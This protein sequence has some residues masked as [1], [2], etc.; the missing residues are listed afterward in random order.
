[1]R[2]HYSAFVGRAIGQS[3]PQLVAQIEPLFDDSGLTFLNI[4]YRLDDTPVEA[5]GTVLAFSPVKEFTLQQRYDDGF[6]QAT[7]DEGHLPLVLTDQESGQRSWA[8][9]Q[10]PKGSIMINFLAQPRDKYHGIVARTDLRFDQGG[11]FG[12]GGQFLPLPIDD[13]GAW[14]MTVHW[15]VPASA[16][17]GTRY[18]SSLGDSSIG[19]ASDLPSEVLEN[20][21]FAVGPLKRWPDWSED[22]TIPGSHTPRKFAF[23]W[24]GNQVWDVDELDPTLEMHI[25]VRLR[26]LAMT[27]TTIMSFSARSSK[28][29]TTSAVK[30]DSVP[31]SWSIL[32]AVKRNIRCTIFTI[33]CP[34]K[35]FTAFPSH[36][37]STI[38]IT[39]M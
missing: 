17:A 10:E 36:N 34:T 6:V 26:I 32:T 14:N 19:S 8:L 24:I 7:D 1:M 37:P 23:Y 13:N 39:G 4:T 28:I 25:S 5:N 16:P 27:H 20:A 18:A 3:L 12:R 15:T 30:E 31:T 11:A 38:T 21:H 33:C 29:S 22:A 9:G 35:P 2:V